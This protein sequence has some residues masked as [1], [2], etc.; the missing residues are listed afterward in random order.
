MPQSF[1]SE[2]EKIMLLIMKNKELKLPNG[3]KWHK[4]LFENAFK[5]KLI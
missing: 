5:T 1:Y 4:E 3:I 2:I